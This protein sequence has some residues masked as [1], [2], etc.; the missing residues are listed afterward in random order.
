MLRE[1]SQWSSIGARRSHLHSVSMSACVALGR[2]VSFRPPR[3]FPPARKATSSIFRANPGDLSKSEGNPRSSS[4]FVSP[5]LT[6]RS[7]FPRCAGYRRCIHAAATRLRRVDASPVLTYG[8]EAA[9]GRGAAPL[10]PCDRPLGRAV[11]RTRRGRR[12][13]SPTDRSTTMTSTWTAW[14]TTRRASWRTRTMTTNQTTARRSRGSRIF[15]LMSQ[16]L[17]P[18]QTLSLWRTSRSDNYFIISD[19]I[20]SSK[21][22]LNLLVFKLF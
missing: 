14:T 21:L 6:E 8:G 17:Q 12:G 15:N 13:G 1:T 16:I 7:L 3:R 5:R 9:I 2:C 19:N 18:G 22:Q 11:G 4:T 20:I 10:R